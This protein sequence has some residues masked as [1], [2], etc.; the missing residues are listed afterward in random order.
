MIL[1]KSPKRADKEVF[2]TT[3]SVVLITAELIIIYVLR[4][5][6]NLGFEQTELTSYNNKKH[7]LTSNV[8]LCRMP[9]VN[10]LTKQSIHKQLNLVLIDTSTTTEFRQ[11]K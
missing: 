6:V 8:Y 1:E 2:I 4:V 10:V 7:V 3:S 11:Q 5:Y 9:S